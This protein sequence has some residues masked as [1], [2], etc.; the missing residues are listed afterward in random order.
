MILEIFCTIILIGVYIIYVLVYNFVYNPLFI[1][2]VLETKNYI[3]MFLPLYHE[4]INNEY[5]PY[6]IVGFSSYIAPRCI[7]AIYLLETYRNEGRF[8]DC[9][10]RYNGYVCTNN[11]KMVRTLEKH[12]Y[13]P[14]INIPY[15]RIFYKSL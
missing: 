11:M 12:G 5:K 13:T 1:N 7:I 8:I 9:L 10:Y 2:Y 15:I 6:Q 14:L 3:L 4:A